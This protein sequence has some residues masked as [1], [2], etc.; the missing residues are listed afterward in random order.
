M[1]T[2]RREW[3]L[4]RAVQILD[5]EA[6]NRLVTSTATTRDRQRLR[7]WQEE[8]LSRLSAEANIPPLTR[9]EFLAAFEG[10]Q[11]Q[12][13]P[14]EP[15]RAVTREEFL[16]DP[17]GI[18]LAPSALP[19]P[20]DWFREAW[21]A[22]EEDPEKS[23]RRH[24]TGDIGREAN[25]GCLPLAAGQLRWLGQVLREDQWAGLYRG[26]RDEEPHREAEM[27]EEFV[28][29][30]PDKQASLPPP[31]TRQEVVAALGELGFDEATAA[32]LMGE[33]PPSDRVRGDGG[34]RF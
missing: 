13:V 26:V 33:V 11:L 32:E 25:K 7:F 34:I 14:N 30:A 27:R 3:L 19:I 4:A 17:V 2:A 15:P 20:A 29:A 5:A 21:D 23:L 22:D 12:P 16:S 24:V 18:Y 10:A 31:L 9:E 28:R 6:F 1:D 8:L